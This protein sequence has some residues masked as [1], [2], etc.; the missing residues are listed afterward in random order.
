MEVNPELEALS[1]VVIYFYHLIENGATTDVREDIVLHFHY[2][3]LRHFVQFLQLVFFEHWSHQLLQHLEC[4][5]GQV[6]FDIV[7]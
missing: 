3:A 2:E 4:A 6:P 5:H 7:L 1:H